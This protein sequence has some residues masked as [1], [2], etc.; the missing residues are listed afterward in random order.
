MLTATRVLTPAAT[1]LQLEGAANQGIIID[2]GDLSKAAQP[3]AFQNGATL[4][5]VKLRG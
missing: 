4:E 3:L 1:F 2:G 5:A